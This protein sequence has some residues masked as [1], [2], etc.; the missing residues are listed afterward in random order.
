MVSRH[1][2]SEKKT[3][4]TEDI[5][6]VTDFDKIARNMKHE[7]AGDGQTTDETRKLA[8]T[9]DDLQMCNQ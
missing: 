2:S 3:H 5:G 8:T 7:S 9:A 6:P 1:T 4:E